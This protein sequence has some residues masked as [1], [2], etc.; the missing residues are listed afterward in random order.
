MPKLEAFSVYDLRFVCSW[1]YYGTTEIK[2]RLKPLIVKYAKNW[3]FGG[4]DN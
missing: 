4:F 3:T 1:G 2:K